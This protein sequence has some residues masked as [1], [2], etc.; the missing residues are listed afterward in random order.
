MTEQNDLPDNNAGAPVKS[1]RKSAMRFIILLGFV[2]LFADVTYEGARSIIGPY[3]SILGASALTVAMVAGFGELVGYG[4]RLFFGYLGDRTGRYWLMTIAGYCINLLAVPL[5]ALANRWEIAAGLV[6]MERAG[7]AVRAPSRDVILSYATKQVGRGWG[8]G[9]H[10]AM[11]QI[12][13]LLGPIIVAI[14]LY[15][16]GEYKAGFLILSIPAILAI[17]VL[18][19]AR[20]LYPVPRELDTTDYGKIE[21]KGFLK[22]FWIY[23]AGIACVAAGYADFP[24]IAF[25]FKKIA[26]VS[27]NWIPIFYSIA[28]GVDAIAALVFG[29]LFD[30]KGM[31][32]LVIAI[33]ISAWAAPFAFCGDFSGAI[34]GVV[35]WGIGMGAQE[36]IMRAA[37]VDMV[38]SNRR[39]SAYGIFNTGYGL[40]WFLGSFAMGTLY[41]FSLF[42]LAAFSVAMQLFS[43]PILLSLA[44]RKNNKT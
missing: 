40:F 1:P 30:R 12:G 2:S 9:I 43:I 27:D 8:F 16:R 14:A 33:F 15:V 41:G 11:D 19:L 31:R 18:L 26:L 35:L 23:L 7:K 42:W 39:G 44:G 29:Y 24:L 22:A 13:A 20:F 6:I 32:A 10:E 36:S 34:I 17:S 4:L 37:I 28:M 3:F 21:S 5:L 38:P 25:H